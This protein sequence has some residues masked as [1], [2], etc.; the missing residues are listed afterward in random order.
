ML[1]NVVEDLVEEWLEKVLPKYDCCK[2]EKCRMDMAA[3]SLNKLKP[4]YVVS[5]DL[6]SKARY[7]ELGAQNTILM[8]VV[9]SVEFV[10][11]HPRHDQLTVK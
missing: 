6:Y 9:T 2:C 11:D 1:H 4:H 8:A 5:R 10:K 3:M 7:L